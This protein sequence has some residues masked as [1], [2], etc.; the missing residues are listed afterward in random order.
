M[1]Y[2]MIDT[3]HLISLNNQIIQILGMGKPHTRNEN[4]IKLKAIKQ[5]LI[6]RGIVSKYVLDYTGRL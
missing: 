6:A 1:N 3:Q 4:E 5:E 2:V